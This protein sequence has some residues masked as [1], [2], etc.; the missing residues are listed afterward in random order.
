MCIRDRRGA[1]RA[2]P[3]SWVVSN[4]GGALQAFARPIRPS[5]EA[6]TA[7]SSN[8]AVASRPI[9]AVT[10]RADVTNP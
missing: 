3:C 4:F 5:G 8:W 1:P 6:W 10:S 7:A 2:G 9:A